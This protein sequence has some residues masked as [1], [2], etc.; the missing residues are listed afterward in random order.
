MEVLDLL[1]KKYNDLLKVR[2]TREGWIKIQF[3]NIII[4]A[5]SCDNITNIM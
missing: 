3:P 5:S 4:P 1:N 2:F